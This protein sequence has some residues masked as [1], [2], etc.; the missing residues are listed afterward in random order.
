MKRLFMVFSL[1]L[2]MLIMIPKNT[3]AATNFSLKDGWYTN[4]SAVPAGIYG[5][6]AAG[7]IKWKYTDEENGIKE[8]QFSLTAKSDLNSIYITLVP[9]ALEIQTVTAGNKFLKV[10]KSNTNILLTANN[11]AMKSGST[12][13]LF[14]V[15]TKDTAKEGCNLSVSP[16]TT[17]CVT[18]EDSYLDKEGKLVDK[19]K[20][21]EV[22]NGVTP[23]TPTDDPGQDVP[24]SPDTG[25]VIPY[26]AIGGGLVAIAGVYLYSR[27]SNKVYK[28]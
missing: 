2:F 13:L 5:E 14:T 27:R 25:S 17:T 22:C 7:G 15:V 18:V 1:I 4:D 20:Y 10:S 24:N 12:E 26:L 11:G 19:A 16:K 21:D 8:W 28:I 3:Y 6:F 23:S 9:N